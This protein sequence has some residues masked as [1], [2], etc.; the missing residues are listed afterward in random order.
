[1]P[2]NI[3][4]L[5]EVEWE[6]GGGRG[7]SATHRLPLSLK[8]TELIDKKENFTLNAEHVVAIVLP[9]PQKTKPFFL[10]VISLELLE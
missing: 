3:Y 2:S 10:S 4:S 6:E 9:P 1:M 5:Y 8:H 7:N